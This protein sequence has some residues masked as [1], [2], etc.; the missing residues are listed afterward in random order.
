MKTIAYSREIPV[1]YE[2]GVLVTGGGPAGIAA[3]VMCAR[4]GASVILT[5]QTGSLGGASVLAM[6]PEIMNFDDGV[7]FLS[8]GFGRELH[9]SLFGECAYRRVWQVTKPE[10]LKRWYDNTV[11]EAG[12]KL[13]LC[14]RLT[15]VI[16][17]GGHITGAIFSGQEGLFAVSA[18]AYIDCT[19]SAALCRLAG[20]GCDWGD[21]GGITMPATLCSLWGGV[22]FDRKRADGAYLRQA[23]SDGV[24][25]EFDTMLPG[26]KPNYP[27]A[28]V[29]GGNVGHVFAA[30]DRTSES[31]TDALLLG[32]RSLAEYERYYRDY[33]EGC[34]SVVLLRTADFLGIRESWRVRCVKT[35]TADHFSDG[36]VWPDEIGRYSYPVDIHPMTAD[37]EGMRG[38]AKSVNIRHGDGESYGIPYGCLLPVGF[39]NLLTA[40]RCIGSDRAMQASARVIPCCYLT[41]QAAGIAVALAL[42]KGCSAADLGSSASLCGELRERLSAV[43]AY[44][45]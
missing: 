33:V 26:I 44:P 13:L 19:G 3:A 8:G 4:Q 15:D 31:I 45:V 18:K 2:C 1:K 20:A 32:R 9:D 22:D 41:G 6:V 30:D 36:Y 23:Y 10:P 14:T 42:D 25:S 34:E 24:L 28:G 5:E 39:D 12:V 37:E 16:M 43:G 40:G 21:E 17:S 27:D 35:L 29:G 11:T 38:F 7:H